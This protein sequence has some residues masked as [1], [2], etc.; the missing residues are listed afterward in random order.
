MIKLYD[1]IFINR[2]PFTINAFVHKTQILYTN[3]RVIKML[4]V[5]YSQGVMPIYIYI[6]NKLP[7]NMGDLTCKVPDI[8]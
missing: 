6:L 1:L 3:K 5:K 7:L 4:K 8:L 2:I